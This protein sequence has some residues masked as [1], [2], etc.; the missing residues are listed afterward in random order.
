[1][2]IKYDSSGTEIWKASAG[3]S[4]G[5]NAPSGL[6][7]DDAG[8][9]L[10]TG[11]YASQGGDLDIRATA[12][13]KSGSALWSTTYDGFGGADEAWAQALWSDGLLD[14]AGYSVGEDGTP[15]FVAL[16]F[17]APE[18]LFLSDFETSELSEWSAVSVP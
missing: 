1:M 18:Y 15:D 16:R 7:V 13:S 10:V 5:Y 14:L 11:D 6:V 9:V 8:A 2:T 17:R 3:G 4:E 12:Y